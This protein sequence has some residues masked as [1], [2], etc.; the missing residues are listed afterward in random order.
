M[1]Q[2]RRREP[3]HASGIAT[4]EQGLVLLDGP[5]GV[6]VAMTPDAADETARS[7][8]AAAAEARTQVNMIMAPSQKI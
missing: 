5:N 2:E 6:A 4:A 7:L 8:T 1:N 3:H